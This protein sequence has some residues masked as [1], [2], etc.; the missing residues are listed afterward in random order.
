MIKEFL[1]YDT[2][3]N[4][5]LK[6]ANKIYKS[7]PVTRTVIIDAETPYAENLELVQYSDGANPTVVARKAYSDGVS[8]KGKW[9]LEFKATD[10]SA[11]NASSDSPDL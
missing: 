9:Y 11:M 4:N 8:V 2:V 1:E 5:A 6:L 3:R 7:Q 10:K